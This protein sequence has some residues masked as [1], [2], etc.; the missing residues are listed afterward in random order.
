M[1]LEATL[2]YAAMEKRVLTLKVNGAAR[3]AAALPSAILL[4]VLREDLNLTGSKR[5]CDMGT[6]G[7][8]TVQ[9]DGKPRLSCLTLAFQ[10]EGREITTI[11]GLAAADG[12]LHPLQKAFA[13]CGGSQCGFCTPGFVM[14]GAAWLKGHPEFSEE[15]LREAVSGNLCRCT[16]Y[17]PIFDAFRKAAEDLA[18]RE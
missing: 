1:I 3:E 18:G 8:C 11:E 7:C 14:N 13:E 12:T 16:G 10:V 4:D 15:E 2:K 17:L 6:C 9:V 5:G